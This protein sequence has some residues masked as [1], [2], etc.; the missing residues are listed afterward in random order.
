MDQSKK[1]VKYISDSFSNMSS[2]MFNSSSSVDEKSSEGIELTNIDTLTSQEWTKDNECNETV[3]IKK[4]E[5]DKL[6]NEL[7]FSRMQNNNYKIKEREYIRIKNDYDKTL[8]YLLENNQTIIKENPSNDQ[9]IIIENDLNR[10]RAAELRLKSHI[11]ALKKDLF[12]SEQKS[13]AF[14]CIA[15]SDMEVLKQENLSLKNNI[16]KQKEKNM[17]LNNKIRRLEDILQNRCE[18][19]IELIEYCKYFMG[20]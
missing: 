12:D 1:I 4:N 3:V 8:S 16:N 18:E 2:M 6:L 7:S 15:M 17:E 5:Y 9:Q 19:S 13:D 11:K 20:K 10:L 14:K